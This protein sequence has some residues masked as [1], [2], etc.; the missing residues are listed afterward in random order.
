MALQTTGG[1]KVGGRLGFREKTGPSEHRERNKRGATTSNKNLAFSDD[2]QAFKNI[3]R[4][5]V[6]SNRP[7]RI[8]VGLLVRM[9]GCFL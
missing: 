1:V 5:E 4:A 2:K 9:R 7:F 3:G 6:I 8:Q